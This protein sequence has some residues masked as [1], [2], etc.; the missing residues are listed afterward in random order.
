MNTRSRCSGQTQ[1]PSGPNQRAAAIKSS[2]KSRQGGLKLQEHWLSGHTRFA[3]ACRPGNHDRT[4]RCSTNACCLGGNPPPPATRIHP[5]QENETQNEQNQNTFRETT[6]A[7]VAASRRVGGGLCFFRLRGA[8]RP[9][10]P[11]KP[12]AY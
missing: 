6:G 7:H 11:Q 3:L 4:A 10:A 2:L 5:K 12:Q 9:C 8:P 1:E